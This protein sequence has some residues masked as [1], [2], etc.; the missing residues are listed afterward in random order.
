M[1]TLVKSAIRQQ[2]IDNEERFD[3]LKNDDPRNETVALKP[4]DTSSLLANNNP[5]SWP[6]MI[7]VLNTPFDHVERIVLQ[8]LSGTMGLPD[9]ADN[10]FKGLFAFAGDSDGKFNGGIP[11]FTMY[12]PEM[13]TH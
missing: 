8:D 10:Y 9:S 1:D 4:N 3:V 2:D 7:D 6:N 5:E 11:G 13:D 12:D